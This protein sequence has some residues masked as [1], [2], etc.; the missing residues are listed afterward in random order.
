MMQSAPAALSLGAPALGSLALAPLL[1]LLSCRLLA[2]QAPR[3]STQRQRCCSCN[4][5]CV[6]PAHQQHVPRLRSQSDKASHVNSQ[7]MSG[8]RRLRDVS[9]AYLLV[10]LPLVGEHAAVQ[11]PALGLVLVPPPPRARLLLL[12]LQQVHTH[13]PSLHCQAGDNAAC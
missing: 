1:R 9:S 2:L 8:D 10:V 5:L 6:Q 13:W 11:R 7:Q 4:S 12:A 3:D